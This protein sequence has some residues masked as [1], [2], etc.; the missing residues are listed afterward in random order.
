MQTHCQSVFDK[1]EDS[2]NTD[3]YQDFHSD[4]DSKN[5]KP[6]NDN[7]ESENPESENPE[8][9]N[10]DEESED[11]YSRYR[12]D[13]IIDKVTNHGK[14]IH[15]DIWKL[16]WVCYDLEKTSCRDFL[17]DDEQF[18][19]VLKLKKTILEIEKNL[20]NL[21]SHANRIPIYGSSSDAGYIDSLIKNA[22]LFHQ[23]YNFK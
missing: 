7:P 5:K 3:P 9:Q 8:N 2:V 6:E 12:Y 23:T 11:K 17:T 18:Q 19:A 10:L 1:D 13:V 20:E 16:N 4:P 14:S 21:K 15:D 22:L